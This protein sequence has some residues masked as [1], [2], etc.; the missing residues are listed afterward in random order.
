MLS[1]IL[2]TTLSINAY[3]TM[4][5]PSSPRFSNDG[6]RIVFAVSR[7]DM[8]RSVYDSDLW[9]ANSDGTN[10]MQLTRSDANDSDPSW[11]P[12]GKRIAFVSDRGTDRK[13]LWLLD[14]NGGEPW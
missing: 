11:S 5:V 4:P 7:A 8:D 6:K 12:D 3:A 13:A 14:P 9:L 1:L 2:A 10:V